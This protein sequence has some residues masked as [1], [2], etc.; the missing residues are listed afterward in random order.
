MGVAESSGGKETEKPN[1]TKAHPLLQSPLKGIQDFKKQGPKSGMP[2]GEGDSQL[3]LCTQ[4]AEAA[5][6]RA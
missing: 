4:E 5:G 2:S 6:L 1:S 3:M